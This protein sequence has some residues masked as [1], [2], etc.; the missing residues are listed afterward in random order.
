MIFTDYITIIIIANVNLEPHVFD[1][2]DLN[3]KWIFILSL[4]SAIIARCFFFLKG[5]VEI[6]SSFF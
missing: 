6:F 3:M 4:Y 1:R 2:L 5:T